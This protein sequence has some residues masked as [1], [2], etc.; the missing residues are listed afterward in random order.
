M[1]ATCLTP[2]RLISCVEVGFARVIYQLGEL[3]T[4][5]AI[6]K[7]CPMA[8]LVTAVDCYIDHSS[9][10]TKRQIERS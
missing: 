3:K 7:Y 9:D 8:E 1:L 5:Q 10:Q 6:E 4:S 2:D